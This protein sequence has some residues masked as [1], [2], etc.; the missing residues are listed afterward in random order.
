[1]MSSVYGPSQAL[2][3]PSQSWSISVL[4]ATTAG[5]ISLK[6]H[7]VAA[8]FSC[9]SCC[10]RLRLIASQLQ[11]S[12]LRCPKIL[13]VEPFPV[14]LDCEPK[15]AG[16]TEVSFPWMRP[17]P[18]VRAEPEVS[19]AMLLITPDCKQSEEKSLPGQPT[20]PVAKAYNKRFGSCVWATHTYY[21][22]VNPLLACG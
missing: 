15:A 2:V 20:V 16:V 21:K 1:M 17:A 14:A 19:A 12:L 7:W 3:N 18:E 5:S 10:S 13:I 6:D 22:R 11:R 9:G 8:A 4:S